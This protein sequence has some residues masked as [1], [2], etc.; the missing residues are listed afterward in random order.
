LSPWG[1]IIPA[2]RVEGEK[3]FSL[4]LESLESVVSGTF[5]AKGMRGS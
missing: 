2:K 3:P 5:F 1:R 4:E